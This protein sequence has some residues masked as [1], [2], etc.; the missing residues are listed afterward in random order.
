MVINHLLNGM[1]LQVLPFLGH[2]PRT[3]R[4]GSFIFF[5]VSEVDETPI[6]M[7]YPYH[8]WVYGIFTDP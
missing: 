8:P 2:F 5:G 6:L 4:E 3:L 7:T 1:I